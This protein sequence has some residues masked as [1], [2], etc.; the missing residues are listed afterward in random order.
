MLIKE[1]EKT[2]KYFRPDTRLL[3]INSE[4]KKILVSLVYGV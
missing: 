2:P 1:Q 3:K 4:I